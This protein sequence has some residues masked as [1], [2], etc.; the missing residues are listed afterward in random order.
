MLAFA[1]R[2]TL[3]DFTFEAQAEIPNGVTVVLGPSGAGKSTLLRFIAGLQRPDAGRITLAGRTLCDIGTQVWVPPQQRNIGLVFQEYALF[4]HL[5]VE[6]NV[7]YG[8]RARRRP[9]AERADTVAR[10][11][12]MLEITHLAKQNVTA[13]S[14]GQRQRVALARALD[15]PLSALDPATRERVRDELAALFTEIRIPALLVTHDDADRKAFGERTL[16]LARGAVV[17][18]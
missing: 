4:P 1:L 9:P 5:S 11:L 14:G 15:E 13:L 8:L 16:H 7:A 6:A 3:R 18:A 2:A 17:A 10:A 12:A